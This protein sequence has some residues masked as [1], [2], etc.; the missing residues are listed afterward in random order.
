[1]SEYRVIGH[2]RGPADLAL[3]TVIFGRCD[4]IGE[5]HCWWLLALS[6][7]KGLILGPDSKSIDIFD[8]YV[9]DGRGD[10]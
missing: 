9:A 6:L 5:C 10:E 4:A 1:M 7:A 8:I 2:M 3:A